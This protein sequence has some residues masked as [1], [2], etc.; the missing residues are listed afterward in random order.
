MFYLCREGMSKAINFNDWKKSKNS[1]FLLR[2]LSWMGFNTQV[3]FLVV[4]R[5]FFISIWKSLEEGK[6]PQSGM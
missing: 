3:G 2:N 1:A 4:R 5:S 6:K